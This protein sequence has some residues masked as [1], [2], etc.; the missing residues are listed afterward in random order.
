MSFTPSD[1]SQKVSADC[2]SVPQIVKAAR[3]RLSHLINGPVVLSA[4]PDY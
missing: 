2:R 4:Q 3:C 1:A